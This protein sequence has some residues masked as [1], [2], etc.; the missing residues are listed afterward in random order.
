MTIHGTALPLALSSRCFFGSIATLPRMLTSTAFECVTPSVPSDAPRVVQ[1]S[2][3]QD[4]KQGMPFYYYEDVEGPEATHTW[5]PGYLAYTGGPI[6]PSY[7][8]MH[9]FLTEGALCDL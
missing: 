6:N 2:I 1:A 4:A 5:N 9:S 3:N 7:F 8:C